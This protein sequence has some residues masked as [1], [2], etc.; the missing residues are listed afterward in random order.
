MTVAQRL[1]TLIFAA[2]VGLASVAGLGMI[3][4]DTV[5]TKTNFSNVNTVPS[6]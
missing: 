4:L 3:Q 1:Y 6:Q 5:Y 2:V